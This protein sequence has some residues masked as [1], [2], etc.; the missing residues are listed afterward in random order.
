MC[1]FV[2]CLLFS[3]RCCYRVRATTRVTGGNG[4][5]NSTRR[6]CDRSRTIAGIRANSMDGEILNLEQDVKEVLTAGFDHRAS[7]NIHAWD[8]FVLFCNCAIVWGRPVQVSRRWCHMQV[9][10]RA[11][12]RYSLGIV[13]ESVVYQ[14]MPWANQ[15]VKEVRVEVTWA[16]KL[17]RFVPLCSK[18]NAT[19]S[20]LTW[21]VV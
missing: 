2:C 19:V 6:L 1:L 18:T 13:I 20:R 7:T 4:L 17:Q 11:T 14:Q 16:C 3:R 12:R 10:A 5:F 21:H 15:N 8:M 9:V